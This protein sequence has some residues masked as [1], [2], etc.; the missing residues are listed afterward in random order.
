MDD[1]DRIHVVLER[2]DKRLS[3]LGTENKKLR[4]EM[5]VLWKLLNIKNI[6]NTLIVEFGYTKN[7]LYVCEQDMLV[8]KE[9]KDER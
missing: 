5:D 2:M 6:D 8:L 4:V 3:A 7:K 9:D 1:I